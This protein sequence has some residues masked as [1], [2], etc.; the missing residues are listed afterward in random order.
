VAEDFFGTKEEEVQRRSRKMRAAADA[1]LQP[2]G[3][4]S[5]QT[6]PEFKEAI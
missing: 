4:L 5:L 1:G 3:Q 6:I 2:R